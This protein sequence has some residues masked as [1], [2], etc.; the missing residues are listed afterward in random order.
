M[1]YSKESALEMM[2]ATDFEELS[3][4]SNEKWN[5]CYDPEWGFNQICVRATAGYASFE[6]KCGLCDVRIDRPGWSAGG[7]I[8]EHLAT[9]GHQERITLLKLAL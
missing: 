6:W 8:D 1:S 2:S 7:A 4:P 9:P 3:I 5:L